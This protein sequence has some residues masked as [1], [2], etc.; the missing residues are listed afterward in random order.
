[1]DRF[2]VFDKHIDEMNKKTMGTL[3]YLNRIK[4]KIDKDTRVVVVQALALSLINYCSKIWGATNKTQIQRVQK[5]QNFAAKVA[6]GNV[7]KFDHATP[8]ISKLGWLKSEQK[9]TYDTCIYIYKVYTKLV[10]AW[11]LTLTT[12]RD[13]NPVIT[14]QQNNLFIQR[15]S[16]LTGAR[17]MSI[18]GP[19]LWNELPNFIKSACSLIVFKK[20]LKEYLFRSQ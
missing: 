1:M 13:V 7:K 19:M 3:I 6:I 8:H 20:R 14:R 4:D 17:E 2:M 18:R 15:T 9:C 5:L 10:P 12:V 11:L 16:T